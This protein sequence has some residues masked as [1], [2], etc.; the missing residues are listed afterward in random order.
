MEIV[1][2]I[3]EP[4]GVSGKFRLSEVSEWHNIF[5]INMRWF[6][7]LALFPL[8]WICK[9]MTSFW[10]DYWNSNCCR[11]LKWTKMLPIEERL[12]SHFNHFEICFS[13]QL[14]HFHDKCVNYWAA[15][16]EYNNCSAHSKIN[17]KWKKNGFMFGG[18]TSV[19]ISLR[20][21]IKF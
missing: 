13:I 3:D 6:E 4:V 9:R 1:S 20:D 11:C 16:N 15:H 2:R 19:I 18:F 8:F 17:S 14:K 12:R 7:G 5:W 21:H 10:L